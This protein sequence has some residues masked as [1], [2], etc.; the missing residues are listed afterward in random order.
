M[1]EVLS[2]TVSPFLPFYLLAAIQGF[3]KTS[4]SCSLEWENTPL[5]LT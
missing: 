3:L 4:R 5:N 1:E 2:L